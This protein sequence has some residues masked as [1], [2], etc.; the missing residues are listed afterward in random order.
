MSNQIASCGSLVCVQ[1]ATATT[2]AILQAR[3]AA[4]LVRRMQPT[5]PRTTRATQN[6]AHVAV[7]TLAPRPLTHLVYAFAA[8]RRRRL[9]TAR[10][11][12][13]TIAVYTQQSEAAIR[14]L[15]AAHW[16]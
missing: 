2:N 1:R 4:Q 6:K 15:A 8:T 7:K 12:V 16:V 5:T 13:E 14:R 3:R 11:T 9:Q 10:P